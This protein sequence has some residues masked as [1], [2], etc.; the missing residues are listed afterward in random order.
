MNEHFLGLRTTIYHVPNLNDAKDWYGK[1]FGSKPYFDE[2]F[3]V[4]FNISGY[5]LGLL[6]S[7]ISAS[8]KTTN[9]EALWGVDDIHKEHNRL[10]SFG[11]TEHQ[12]PGNVGGE[13][14][15]S[16][17]KD[18]WGNLIGLIFNPHFKLP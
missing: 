14:M 5:E 16:S 11:A 15:V 1:A 12:K 8:E 9:I 13:I 17:V 2:P 10:I 7:D 18:P 3:Y 4:G 6:P